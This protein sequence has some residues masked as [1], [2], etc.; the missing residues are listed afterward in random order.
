MEDTF[1]TGFKSARRGTLKAIALAAIA[2]FALG[3]LAALATKVF[4]DTPKSPAAVGG[5]QQVAPR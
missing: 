1:D 2:A 3:A 4:A 5:V